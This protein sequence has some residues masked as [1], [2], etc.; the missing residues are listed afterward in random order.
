MAKKIKEVMK[1]AG[2]LITKAWDVSKG[3]VTGGIF[4]ATIFG[5]VVCGMILLCTSVID[6]YGELQGYALVGTVFGTLLT[7]PLGLFWKLSTE[8]EI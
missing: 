4:W 5:V 7:V 1:K 3:Y 8:K 6:G 2:E